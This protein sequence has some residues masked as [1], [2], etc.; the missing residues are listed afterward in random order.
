MVSVKKK[1]S[2]GPYL[3]FFFLISTPLKIINS[4]FIELYF[5]NNIIIIKPS[6][7]FKEIENEIEVLGVNCFRGVF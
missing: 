7:N 4:D 3:L 6:I 2:D 1:S 5:I